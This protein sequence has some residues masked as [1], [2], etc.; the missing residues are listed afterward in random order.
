MLFGKNDFAAA[1]SRPMAHSL[2]NIGISQI[3]EKVSTLVDKIISECE[4]PGLRNLT[5][6]DFGNSH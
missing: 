6:S 4:M 2:K 1:L 3:F 5:S